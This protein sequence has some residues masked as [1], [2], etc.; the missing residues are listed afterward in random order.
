M[1]DSVTLF[2]DHEIEDEDHKAINYKHIAE[3]L[4]KDWGFYYTVTTN[5]EAVKDTFDTYIRIRS[6]KT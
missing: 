2:L 4:A 1:K 5:M 6:P 3:T